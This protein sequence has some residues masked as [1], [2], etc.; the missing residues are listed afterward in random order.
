MNLR[1]FITLPTLFFFTANTLLAAPAETS[2]WKERGEKLA[3]LPLAAPLS[4]SALLGFLPSARPLP[5]PLAATP[6]LDS[7]SPTGAAGRLAAALPLTHVS[8]RT[9][10]PGRLDRPAVVLIQDIHLNP[11]AQANIAIA[12]E[13][14]AT[15]SPIARVGVEGAFGPLRLSRLDGFSDR[16]LVREVAGDFVKAGA[17]A[18]PSFLGA[19]LG[20]DRRI[21]LAGVDDEGEYHRDVAAYRE[22][23]DEQA[24]L[25]TEIGRLE[26]R[27]AGLKHKLY[28]P[29]LAELDGVVS[30]YHRGDLG[31]GPYL[32]RLSSTG[33][34][35]PFTVRNFLEAYA[36]E[37]NLNFDRVEEERRRVIQKLAAALSP[38]ELKTLL[39][40][41]VAYRSG[42]LS[43]AAFHGELRAL[44]RRKGIDLAATPAFDAYV[45][46]VL[47]ADGISGE[48]L[49]RDAEAL[50][51]AAFDRLAVTAEQRAVAAVSRRAETLTRL[52]DFA[53]APDEWERLS[54]TPFNVADIDRAIGTLDGEALSARPL[55]LRPFFDFYR[56]ADVRSHT[57]VDRLLAG[58]PTAVALVVGGFHTPLIE[59]LLEARGCALVVSSPRLTTVDVAN[60]TAYL[61]IFSRDKTP[62][63]K[64][65]SGEKLSINPERVNFGDDPM[66]EREVVAESA[67]RVA[68]GESTGSVPAGVT[69]E[70]R[71]SVVRVLIDGLA[72]FFGRVARVAGFRS[73]GIRVGGHGFQF[74]PLPSLSDRVRRGLG[75]FRRTVRE[76]LNLPHVVRYTL[77]QQTPIMVSRILPVAFL[78]ALAGMIIGSTG[79]WIVA[80]VGVTLLLIGLFNVKSPQN[81]ISSGLFLSVFLFRVPFSERVDDTLTITPEMRLG[82]L[83]FIARQD[84]QRPFAGERDANRTLRF[85][86][87]VA[88]DLDGLARQV[89]TNPDALPVDYFVMHSPLWET[90]VGKDLLAALQ[91]EG[92]AHESAI[93]PVMRRWEW[94]IDTFGAFFLTFRRPHLGYPHRIWIKKQDVPRL[95]AIIA[96]QRV[97]LVRLADYQQR[98]WGEVT[99][100]MNRPSLRGR[101][102][103][104]FGF[105]PRPSVGWIQMARVTL[106]NATGEQRT[107]HYT[108]PAEALASAPGVGD[109]RRVTVVSER[110]GSSAAARTFVWDDGRLVP[111]TSSPGSPA[112]MMEST[113]AYGRSQG[114]TDDQTAV[115]IAP[116]RELGHTLA[117]FSLFLLALPLIILTGGHFEVN[118]FLNKHDNSDLRT[119]LDR[120]S[121][122]AFIRACSMIALVVSV[123]ITVALPSTLGSSLGSPS[124]IFSPAARIMFGV[125]LSLASVSFAQ[126]TAHRSFNR[127]AITQTNRPTLMTPDPDLASR[128]AREFGER[129]GLSFS[130]QSGGGF[131]AYLFDDL[132]ELIKT[133][134]RPF[135][136]LASFFW[137]PLG[138][139]MGRLGD[140]FTPTLPVIM[141]QGQLRPVSDV[142]EATMVV[143]K[144]VSGPSID[145]QLTRIF[146]NPAAT[147]NELTAILDR[148]YAFLHGLLTAG[149]ADTDTRKLLWN[150]RGEKSITGFD[151]SHLRELGRDYDDGAGAAITA[152]EWTLAHKITDLA[153]DM[154]RSDLRRAAESHLLIDYLS[155]RGYRPHRPDPKLS[156]RSMPEWAPK[157][158]NVRTAAPPTAMMDSTRDHGRSKGLTDS[159]TAVQIAPRRELRYTLADYTLFLLAL[160]LTFLTGGHFQ[161]TYF[162]NQHGAQAAS[163]WRLQGAVR[164][165][166]LA[167][168]VALMLSGAAFTLLNIFVTGGA[169]NPL[170]WAAMPVQVL[171]GLLIVIP[172]VAYAQVKAHRRYNADVV[173][174]RR[175][176]DALASG[177]TEAADR[178]VLD[179][180]TN[181][182]SPSLRLGETVQ[183]AAPLANVNARNLAVHVAAEI[184][185]AVQ[186][187][188]LSPERA[189][190]GAELIAALLAS[191]RER[192]RPTVVEEADIP[193]ASDGATPLDVFRWLSPNAAS[194]TAEADAAV[195]RWA[196]QR[197][198][199][200]DRLI[201]M[202]PIGQGPAVEQHLAARPG[203]G[204]AVRV[205][206]AGRFQRVADLLNDVGEFQGGTLAPRRLRFLVRNDS[207]L[208]PGFFDLAGSGLAPDTVA[209]LQRSLEVY[210][211]VSELSRA[212]RIEGDRLSSFEA[213]RAVMIQA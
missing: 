95:H 111:E 78:V 132:G 158:L 155:A 183:G 168:T 90:T 161:V 12:L 167:S 77:L 116:R 172:A 80:A 151:F 102:K 188:R 179:L 63:E 51:R 127:W 175:I 9:V 42:A 138:L 20:P 207:G 197:R 48:R 169:I 208:P 43:L 117:D 46:Y 76:L 124:N 32:R 136:D 106:V 4:S 34:E 104:F 176:V 191:S 140:L 147:P 193:E 165:I 173:W 166:R 129:S 98:R 17:L 92:I 107:L 118:Y 141:S 114:L 82:S 83:H 93:D 190:A 53:L 81:W 22:A 143:Q 8:L 120:K 29:A 152:W 26:S 157:L 75:T 204:G 128:A 89:E 178:Q 2:L 67:A 15:N 130:V 28:S 70:R 122:I 133:P 189:R 162:L 103:R 37:Q 101:L 182:S 164:S 123:A 10:R 72:F 31:L 44:C 57:M 97:R 3:S 100:L 61:T 14:L 40:Q 112:A 113:R 1:R 7:G 126:I 156:F 54:A 142:N 199:S 91:Q 206:E 201:L 108:G 186:E 39:D 49:T 198:T 144:I 52:V 137:Q 211:I 13:R 159:E 180:F 148:A 195:T 213:L 200:G 192:A 35:I 87:Q 11:E 68:E 25:R 153:R 60:G 47:L 59:R 56:L 154:D 105:A 212:V 115:Q 38:A 131:V 135:G 58:N 139:V 36:I 55:D 210:L 16:K 121:G 50:E 209:A 64:L 177:S 23:S 202:V 84:L 145:Q 33:S 69:A 163:D 94:L 205:V 73:I 21:E 71:G 150:L 45:R 110:A 171:L 27:L 185:T 181:G 160:P 18:A 24:A 109:V 174:A 41:A 184:K 6:P 134:Y 5:S 19:A 66:I 125:F 146:A 99:V 203:G 74:L 96:E 62:I 65:F 30:G 149:V 88:D 196:M 86:T 187:R 79:G 119:V 194:A 85:L 170:G